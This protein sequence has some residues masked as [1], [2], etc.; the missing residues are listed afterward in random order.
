MKDGAAM[1]E[2]KVQ[3][4]SDLTTKGFQ[5]VRMTSGLFSS[6]K[7]DWETPDDLFKQMDQEFNFTLDACADQNNHKVS[8]YFN[9]S[10]NS[11]MNPWPGRVWCN[12]PYGRNLINWDEISARRSGLGATN[13]ETFLER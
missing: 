3:G 12:P 7:G 9:E 11:L 5:N 8:N 4:M 6:I 1:K 13:E 2:N 10:E